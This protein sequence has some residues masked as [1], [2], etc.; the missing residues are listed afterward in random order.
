[1]DVD[2]VR[3]T[4]SLGRHMLTTMLKSGKEWLL[5]GRW[6]FINNDFGL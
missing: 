2:R 4:S 1:M 5:K 3:G 6:M